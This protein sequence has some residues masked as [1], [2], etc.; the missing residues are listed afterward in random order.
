M[1]VPA[2]RDRRRHSS[3]GV[4]PSSRAGRPP[5]P[6]PWTSSPTTWSGRTRRNIEDIW[7]VLYRGGFYRGGAVHMSALAGIDQ[8]L[9][10]IK[11]KHHGVPVHDLLGGAGPRPHQG[12]LLDR[13]RPAGRDRRGG[14]RR[15]RPR[16][17][18][19][20][21]ERHRG[22]AVHRLAGTRSTRCVQSVATVRDAVGPNIGVAVDFHGRVHKPMAKVLHQGARAL[23]ADVHRGAG[24]Q[25]ARRRRARRPA[26]RLDPDRARGAAVL[27]LGL[28]ARRR[29][30]GGRHHPARP[31]ALRRH[32]RD[33]QD[34]HDGRGL[35][36]R[37]SPC[38][39]PSA[40]SPSP[41]A[42]SS[43]RSPTTRSSRSRAS[44]ST[45]TRATTCSTT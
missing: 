28:Q 26:R 3:A 41:P 4:S 39:A 43:T 18:R 5:S 2:R 19:G 42:C 37:A 13:R 45:T 11:G 30:R 7:T 21:D 16:V 1:A 40:R 9:W 23:Q 8:A 17:R 35:R 29:Q 20:Q 12:L 15:G 14:A 6:P 24:A 22:D 32:H 10:D 33:P 34:R 38:T 25:R 44:A 36:R 27:A 31:V